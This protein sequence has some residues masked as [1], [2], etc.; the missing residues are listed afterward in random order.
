[1]VELNFS[2]SWLRRLSDNDRRRA[3]LGLATSL[4]LDGGY[5][6]FDRGDCLHGQLWWLRE[7]DVDLGTPLQRCEPDRY[8]TGTFARQFTGGLVVVNP[9]DADVTVSLA[10]DLV[11][12]SS[13]VS[14]KCFVVPA[15]DARL[16]VGPGAK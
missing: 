7:Y 15:N 8:G 9:T 14:G 10:T 12:A 6:G 4:L 5:F 1:M 16:L 2:A 3:R 11:D 13:G